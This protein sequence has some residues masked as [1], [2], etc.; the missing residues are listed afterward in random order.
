L[1]NPESVLNI[2]DKVIEAN[3]ELR[4]TSNTWRERI[5]VDIQPYGNSIHSGYP[6]VISY[7]TFILIKIESQN[8]FYS[9]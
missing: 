1:K 5:V 3:H 8:S 2:W 9:L 6:V 4:G 7:G